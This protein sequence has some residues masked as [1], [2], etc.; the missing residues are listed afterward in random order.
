MK[1]TQAASGAPAIRRVTVG[2]RYPE[3]RV[4]LLDVVAKR[5][6]VDRSEVL[7]DAADQL[8]EAEF[9]GSTKAA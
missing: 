2:F 7:A 5:R 3:D 9:P 6:G 1:D 8:L 4:A